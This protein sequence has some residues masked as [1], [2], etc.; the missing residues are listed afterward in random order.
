MPINNP[1]VPHRKSSLN[2]RAL[3]CLSIQSGENANNQILKNLII[4]AAAT[5]TSPETSAAAP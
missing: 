5:V 3:L 1:E 4:I 2:A